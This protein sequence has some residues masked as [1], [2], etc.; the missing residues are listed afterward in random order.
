MSRTRSA[1]S[2]TCPHKKNKANNKIRR[3][4]KSRNNPNSNST[5]V[6]PP[7]ENKKKSKAA[8]HIGHCRWRK[9]HLLQLFVFWHVRTEVHGALLAL[10]CHQRGLLRVRVSSVCARVVVVVCVCEFGGGGDGGGGGVCA[11]SATQVG[12]SVR[13]PT[14]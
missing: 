14:K 12:K 3:A 2:L 5:N 9:L 4:K 10:H 13:H 8:Y 6:L 1:I 7:K 11:T